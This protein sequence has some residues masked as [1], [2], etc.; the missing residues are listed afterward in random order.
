MVLSTIYHFLLVLVNKSIML[1]VSN[2]KRT[3]RTAKP[4]PDKNWK[5]QKKSDGLNKPIRRYWQKLTEVEQMVHH[6]AEW[7]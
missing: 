1:N 4:I 5:N 7:G 2:F 3:E 6:W